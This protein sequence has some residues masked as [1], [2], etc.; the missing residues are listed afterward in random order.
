MDG[1]GDGDRRRGSGWSG[2]SRNAVSPGANKRVGSVDERRSSGLAEG[3]RERL[4]SGVGVET[5]AEE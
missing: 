2:Y 4:R 1:D 3:E 5:V